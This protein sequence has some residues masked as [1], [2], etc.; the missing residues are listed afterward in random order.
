MRGGGCQSCSLR[1]FD[2]AAPGCVYIVFHLDLLAQKVGIAAHDRRRTDRLRQHE[3]Y[4]WVIHGT[5][6]FAVGAD[7]QKVETAVLRWWRNELEAPQALTNEDMPQNGSTE[8]A[9]LSDVNVNETTAFIERLVA[10]D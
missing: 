3:R 5:W 6:E 4:G 7:A 10:A 9:W 2:P 1:G 8:T